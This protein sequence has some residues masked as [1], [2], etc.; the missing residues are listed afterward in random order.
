M[1]TE[2]RHPPVNGVIN[3][4]NR[5]LEEFQ[6]GIQNKVIYLNIVAPIEQRVIKIR[7]SESDELSWKVIK[8][9]EK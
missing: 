8:V 1:K 5:Y 9:L 7:I 4:S 2:T 3:V 6:E